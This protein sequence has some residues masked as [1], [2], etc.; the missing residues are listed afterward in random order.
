MTYDFDK[1]ISR[2]ETHSTK[3]LKFPDEDIIPMWIADMDF[4][5][6]PEIIQIM[7]QRID[8]GVFGYTKTPPSLTDVFVKKVQMNTG[9]KIDKDW[10]V[11]VPG[12]VVA[13]NVSCKT[14]LA[15]GEMTMV[16]SPIYAPFTEAPEN[17]E[18]GFVKTH[19]KDEKGR[20]EFDIEAIKTLL[21]DDTK[22]FFLCNPHNP[23]GTVF[24]ADEI[25]TI[26]RI[27][28]EKNII[29]CSDEIHSELILEEGLEHIP[30][31]SFSKY[32][33]ENSITIMGPCKTYNLAGFPIAAA[34]IPNKELRDDFMRNTKGIVAHIDSIAFVAAEAAYA[35]TDKWHKELIQY[36]KDN[37]EMLVK[38]INKIK[39][40]SLRGP[41][42]GFLAWID[43]RETGL[44]NPS[45]FFIDE[46]KVGVYDGAWFGNKDYVRLNFGCPRF[47][48]EEAINRIEKAFSQRI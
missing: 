20:L 48:L 11:W 4:A 21:T 37:R 15:P 12:G 16:P 19:L 38:R 8:E 30:F 32:N 35:K 25:K 42:A 33:E 39:G 3:W 45:N 28:E 29:V 1:L 17:M 10:I 43:C 22:M 18:R 24:N 26:S 47:L 46:A 23:G 36:L 31:A 13:L 2:K 5:C 27:C 9:W 14:V 44:E 41:E 6:P 40:L 7:S 34:I